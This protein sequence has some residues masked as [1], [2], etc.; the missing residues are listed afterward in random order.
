MSGNLILSSFDQAIDIRSTKADLLEQVDVVVQDAVNR[1]DHRV[2]MDA[3]RSLNAAGHLS[4]LGLAKLLY[5]LD[6]RW[7]HFPVDE[8]YTFEDACYL[9]IGI[10]RVTVYKYVRLWRFV[11]LHPELTPPERDLLM[12]K[13][14]GALDLLTAAAR[15]DQ[16][17][18]DDWLEILSAPDKAT[19]RE[20][21]RRIRG[22]VG[23]SKSAVTLMYHRD[24][25][26]TA[27]RGD[28]LVPVCVFITETHGLSE[29][30][31]EI[32]DIAQ[33]RM[34]RGAGVVVQQ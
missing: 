34:V 29:E 15:E 20:I 25:R 12:T 8:S 10:S 24:G 4:G 13:P 16:I 22:H 19:I 3:G 6:R 32:L 30:Q 27:R 33:E 1:G 5:E 7:K 23:P 11:I 14:I 2:A 18:R 9:E 21:V 31:L 28:I 26:V 17:T